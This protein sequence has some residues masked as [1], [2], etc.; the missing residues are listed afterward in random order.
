ME[1]QLKVVKFINPEAKFSESK[2]THVIIP[3]NKSSLFDFVNLNKEGS[4]VYISKSLINADG[5]LQFPTEKVLVKIKISIQIEDLLNSLNIDYK[6]VSRLGSDKNS[7]LIELENGESIRIANQLYESGYFEYAQPSFTRLIKMQNEFY[8]NQWGLN[9][10]GQN[11]GTAGVDI[12]APEAWTLTRGCTIIRVAV[13]DQGV[14]LDHPD[15]VANLLPG[16]D[17][18]DGGDGGINGDCW[19]NDAHGTCCAG[20]LGAVN[21]TI[22]TIGVAHNCGIIPIR[23]SYTRNNIQIWNDDWMVNAINHAWDDDNADIL[24]CSWGGGT[25]VTAVNNEIS[26]AL[27]QGRNNQGCIV[28]FSTGNNNTTVNWPANSNSDIIAV[29]AMSPCGERKN[30]NSCDNEDWYRP[31]PYNDYLGGSNYG[32]EIDLIAPGVFIATSDI[33]GSAGY[34]TTVGP[35]G[36]YVQTFNGTSS[37]TPHVAG[38]AALILSINP[39]LTQDQVRDIIESTCTKVG[40][41]NYSTVTGRNNGSW[42]Q[43]AGYGCVNAYAAVQA[44]YPNITGSSLIC[45]SGASFTLNNIPP[46]DSIIWTCGPYLTVS[47]G[48]YTSSCTFS[49]TGNNSSWV[50]ARLVTGCGSIVLQKTVWSGVPRVEVTGPSEGYA[51]GSYTYYAHPTEG[52]QTTSY[53]WTLNPPYDG[54]Y[55]YGYGDWANTSF[56]YPNGGYFQIGCTGHNNCGDGIM[57]T[58]YI[59]ISENGLDYIVSP[60]PASATVTISVVTA[61]AGAVNLPYINAVYDVS[62]HDMNGVLQSRKEYSGDRFTI[63]V[64]NLKDGNYLIRIDNGKSVSVK[65]LIIN[66]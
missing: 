39:G 44:V 4:V 36:N 27:N 48:Q 31:Y 47:S 7:F 58:A 35:G 9:N 37:A 5:I 18:T 61:V 14:D 13:I 24:S 16:F 41:Y 52:S 50:R 60:N 63:P 21:N 55:I 38:V 2:S 43:E 49:S 8:P 6:S 23:V 34:N 33:Q 51:G 65:Q 64:N 10:T 62:I 40:S 12:N 66:R 3:L 45:S 57:G 42:H 59:L 28:V 17:A 54:N 11:G 32:N 56:N 20:I 46:V 19:G 15:L 29:G 1:D 30:P 25:S 22:G 26:A 53:Q